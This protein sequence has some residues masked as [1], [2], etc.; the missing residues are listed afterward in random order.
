MNHY[1][2]QVANAV[3]ATTIHSPTRFSW[4]GKYSNPYPRRQIRA[5]TSVTARTLLLFDLQNQLYSNFYCCGGARPDLEGETPIPPVAT[6]NFVAE[7]AAANRAKGFC[8]DAGWNIREVR[9]DQ[10]LVRRDR[11]EVWA[12]PIDCLSVRAKLVPGKQLSLRVSR[13]A[14]EI[15]PGFYFVL[16]KALWPHKPGAI[17]RYYWN[18]TVEGALRF[19]RAAPTI[20]DRA[21]VPF[22]LKVANHPDRYNRCD[23]GVLYLREQDCEAA[24]EQLV[25]IFSEVGPFL[26]Q[27][28]PA[29]TKT[30]APGLGWAEDPGDSDTTMHRNSF[31]THR[32]HLLADGIVCAYERHQTSLEDR[33]QVVERRLLE[34]GISL[35][36]PFRNFRRRRGCRMEL[37]AVQAKACHG[38]KLTIPNVPGDSLLRRAQEIGQRIAGEAI[39]DGNRC[40]WLGAAPPRAVREP[41]QEEM[42]YTPL[43]VD[44]YS[45]TAGV[46]L[47]L[48]ELCAE[49]GKD[50]RS[51]AIGAISQSFSRAESVRPGSRLALYTGWTGIALAA[52][53]VGIITG[54]GKWVERSD[55]LVRQLIREEKELAGFD[56]LSGKAGAIVG[57]LALHRV[58]ENAQL[59]QTAE[60]LGNEL[61]REARWDRDACS[62]KSGSV[63]SHQNLTGLSQ[64]TAGAAYALLALFRETA[65]ARYRKT[66]VGAFEYERRSFDREASNWPDFRLREQQ[67]RSRERPGVVCFGNSWSH[68]APGIVL[69]RLHAFETLKCESYKLEV[70]NATNTIRQPLDDWRKSH[71]GNWSF[72]EGLGGNCEVL[73]CASEILQNDQGA[74]RASVIKIVQ[75][76]CANFAK[77]GH[78]WPCGTKAGETPS[79][80]LGLSGIGY[81]CL[82]LAN[83]QIPSVLA[84]PAEG[85]PR[86]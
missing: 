4:F 85:L 49:G 82:R 50:L 77:R 75:E 21:T 46:A 42:K 58:L 15:S 11:L 84:L 32:C 40:N 26:K 61:I 24:S 70:M 51:T 6:K 28:T 47:F 56:L 62:W 10:V 31:G 57:L 76:A 17:V 39:W 5:F 34:E 78:H 71:S 14:R 80:M 52:A 64:G 2:E 18:L 38:V 33:L 7:L 55:Q 41:A 29:L 66:A 13:E 8:V 68:G 3:R 22:R 9:K 67:P 83:P 79:L 45:G 36:E 23:A 16:G 59:L 19:L 48:A 65:D 1:R 37:L 81:L 53:R 35:E 69:S 30:L 44:I 72:A 27:W 60:W 20:L 54:E 43:G 86:S 25:K 63:K 12:R 74:V 73:L